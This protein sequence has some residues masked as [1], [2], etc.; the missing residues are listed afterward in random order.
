EALMLNRDFATAV[1]LWERLWRS[2]P[3]AQTLA[4]LIL[5]SIAEKKTIPFPVTD[6]QGAS[7]AFV[8]WYQK[9]LAVRAQALAEKINGRLELLAS[10]LPTAARMLE[11]A[12]AEAGAIVDG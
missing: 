8:A 7:L 5:C 12:L 11:T 10:V 2:E 3:G 6:E 1:E 9:L 4:A